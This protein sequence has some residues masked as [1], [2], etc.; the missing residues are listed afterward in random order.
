MI[1]LANSSM[2]LSALLGHD[3]QGGVGDAATNLARSPATRADQAQRRASTKTPDVPAKT[4]TARPSVTVS[5]SPMAQAAQAQADSSLATTEAKGRPARAVGVSP[6]TSDEQKKLEAIQ[7]LSLAQHR[8]YVRFRREGVLPSEDLSSL[9][10]IQARQRLD[11]LSVLPRL[12]A[13]E[14]QTL[15]RAASQTFVFAIKDGETTESMDTYVGWLKERAQQSGTTATPP[16]VGL[17]I[18]V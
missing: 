14:T 12:R 11:D 8:D 2:L 5:L 4:S 16:K 10:P 17:N 15:G 7:K 6:F 3:R 9:T 13:V 18:Q 1:R